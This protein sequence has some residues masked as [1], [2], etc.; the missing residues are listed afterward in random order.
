M[1]WLKPKIQGPATS[2]TP[3]TTSIHSSIASGNEHA[4]AAKMKVYQYDYCDGLLK[5]DRRS[6][7]YASADAIVA[8]HGTILAETERVVDEALLDE[9]GHIRAVQLPLRETVDK[10][11]PGEP[12][13]GRG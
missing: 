13:M 1:S 3:A 6:V 12:R 2:T 11:P 9:S 7:D 4:S 8:K 10:V 5:H